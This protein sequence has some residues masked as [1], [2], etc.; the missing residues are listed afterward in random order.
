MGGARLL[1]SVTGVSLS[2]NA[3]GSAHTEVNVVKGVD[4]GE[5][6]ITFG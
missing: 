4:P 3:L 5:A 2:S 6:T 1:A